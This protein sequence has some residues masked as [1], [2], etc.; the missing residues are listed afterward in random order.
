[1]K[2]IV[3]L[4]CVLLIGCQETPAQP[5]AGSTPSAPEFEEIALETSP[6]LESTVTILSEKIGER[7]LNHY[8]KL[9]QTRDYITRRLK[10]A[11]YEVELDEFKVDQP[12]YNLVFT[13]PGNEEILVIGAHYD[14]A[15]ITPG[16][17]DNGS[18]VAVLLQLAERLK[19]VPMERTVRFVFFVNEEPPYFMGESMGSRVYAK[20]CAE[21]KDKIVGMIS[22]ETM[23]YY[24]D[25]E[26]SQMFPPGI[27][28]YP[29]TGNF[30]AFISEPNSQE[31]LQECLDHF[32]G[33]PVESL[34]APASIEGVSWSDHAS[35]WEHGFPGVMVTDTAPFRYPHYHRKTDTA[36]QLDYQKLG[37]A[38]DGLET[39][40]RFLGR[41]EGLPG[42]QP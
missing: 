17:N 38:A 13:K 42:D 5:A 25:V 32:Q 41:A 34:V 15:P 31:F 8:P 39:M 4:F 9:E 21:R 35:F 10:K 27:E 14:S 36:D 29:N 12:V 1:M 23:G 18:G 16:A 2:W 37:L 24:S 20:R 22:L 11:G 3:L 6:T 33:L 40:I 7:N 19:Q 28:G 30:L 26:G